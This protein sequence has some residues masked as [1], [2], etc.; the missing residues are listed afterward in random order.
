MKRPLGGKQRRQEGAQVPSASMRAH[1]PSNCHPLSGTCRSIR[2]R[3]PV[4]CLG[5]P[6]KDLQGC[7]GQAVGSPVL[8]LVQPEHLCFCTLLTRPPDK[9]LFGKENSWRKIP[10]LCFFVCLKTKELEQK[11]RH[12]TSFS[13]LGKEILTHGKTWKKLEDIK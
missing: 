8:S 12:K 4:V 10:S 5:A 9:I 2:G 1:S 3:S 11:K 13:C 7:Q 6:G